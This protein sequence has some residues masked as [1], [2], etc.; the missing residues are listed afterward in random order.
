MA[1]KGLAPGAVQDY[2]VKGDM[3]SKQLETRHALR[4]GNARLCCFHW[5]LPA[6]SNWSSRISFL[7][8]VIARTAHAAHLHSPVCIAASLTGYRGP[9]EPEQT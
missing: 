5:R 2:L 4:R 1:G 9:L 7:S 6:S 3:S 8:H